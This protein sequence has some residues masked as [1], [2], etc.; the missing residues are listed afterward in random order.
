MI[1]VG[2]SCGLVALVSIIKADDNNTVHASLL[3]DTSVTDEE[4]QVIHALCSKRYKHSFRITI[5]H[6]NGLSV[7]DVPIKLLQ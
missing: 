2:T 1:A 3:K 5:G 4:G 6:S 7:W